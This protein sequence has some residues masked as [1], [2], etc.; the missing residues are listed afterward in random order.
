MIEFDPRNLA[1][2]ERA[3]TAAN[4]VAGG[5]TA[6][7]DRDPATDPATEDLGAAN[8]EEATAVAM[9]DTLLTPR[10]YTTDFDE[11]DRIDVSSVRADWDELIGR[12]K[13]DP[14]KKHF[15]KGEG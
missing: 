14:N 10:F 11:L 1:D 7:L 8:S 4:A 6:V 15:R 13:A 2:A 12:M 5:A 3:R 9:Q